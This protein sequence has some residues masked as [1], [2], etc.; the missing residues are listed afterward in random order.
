M[1]EISNNSLYRILARHFHFTIT[2]DPDYLIYSCFGNSYKKFSCTRIFYTGENLRPNFLE[3]DYA[4]SFDY[5]ETERNFRLPV[6][7]LCAQYDQVLK[8][9]NPDKILSEDR[10]FCGFL[11]TNPKAKERIT[12]FDKLSKYKHVDAG[13]QIRNNIGRVISDGM[14]F[15]R[16]YK[17]NIAFENS[18]HPGYTTEKIVNSFAAGTVPIYWGNPRIVEDF[19]SA[20]FINCY[21]FDSFDEVID[22]IRKVDQDDDLYLHYLQQSVFPGGVENE[23]AREENIIEKFEHIF[24][25]PKIFVSSYTKVWQ[26]FEYFSGRM[27]KRLNPVRRRVSAPDAG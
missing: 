6:Y 20:A 8:P 3:C 10:K 22:H 15:F 24:S 16:D 1:Q 5:P 13:G 14:E 7:R 26:K 23:F 9:R 17:F 25:S 12:F 2:P 27:F 11:Y 4:F 18:E 19:N 21:D